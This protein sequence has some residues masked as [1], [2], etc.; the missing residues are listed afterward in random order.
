MT[1]RHTAYSTRHNTCH[2]RTTSK[3][4][5]RTPTIQEDDFQQPAAASQAAMHCMCCR[6]IDPTLVTQTRVFKTHAI[7][8]YVILEIQIGSMKFA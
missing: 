3:L 1:D 2:T 7:T 5:P 4:A 6:R 8:F